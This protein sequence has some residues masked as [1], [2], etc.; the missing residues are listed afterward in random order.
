MALCSHNGEMERKVSSAVTE[1]SKK[2]R[3]G[4]K[5]KL[6]LKNNKKNSCEE[7]MSE[8]SILKKKI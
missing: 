6:E 8:V 1:M 4:L 2:K 7:G 5:R 3:S